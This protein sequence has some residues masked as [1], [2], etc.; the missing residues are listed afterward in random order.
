MC[1]RGRRAGIREAHRALALTARG[2]ATPALRGGGGSMRI[3]AKGFT[4]SR[5]GALVPRRGL[6]VDRPHRASRAPCR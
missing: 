3:R 5:P 4:H 2:L 6:G 1:E